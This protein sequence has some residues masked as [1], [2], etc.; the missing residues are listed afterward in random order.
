MTQPPPGPRPAIALQPALPASDDMVTY[1][2][3]VTYAAGNTHEHTGLTIVQA[4]HGVNAFT[5]DL[6]YLQGKGVAKFVLEME[7]S[8]S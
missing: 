6:L 1:K 3:S 8:G 4:E 7:E 2:I 5:S